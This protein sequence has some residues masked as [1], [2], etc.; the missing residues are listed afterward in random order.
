MRPIQEAEKIKSKGKECF[1]EIREK[2]VHIYLISPFL[3]GSNFL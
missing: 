2:V 1:I 3:K